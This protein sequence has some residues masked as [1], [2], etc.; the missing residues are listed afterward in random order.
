MKNLYLKIGTYTGAVVENFI[1]KYLER[2]ELNDS[3]FE[4]AVNIKIENNL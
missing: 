2:I 4:T 3:F 1:G